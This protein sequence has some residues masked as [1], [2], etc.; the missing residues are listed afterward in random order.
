V[1]GP[2][3]T[4][5]VVEGRVTEWH[6][7][8]RSWRIGSRP[9]IMGILN[10]TPDSFSDGG[11]FRDVDAA[12]DHGCRMEEAGADIIDVGGESTRPGSRRIP[13]EEE[14][15]RVI[16]VVEGLAQRVRCA[17]SV[18][19]TK[20]EV[21]ERALQAGADI[22][23]DVS[24]GR[25]DERMLPVV[26]ASRAGMVLM[27]MKGEP[28]T[29]QAD[30]RYRDVVGE[31][32]D[33]LRERIS[34]CLAAGIR[35]EALAIDPGIGFG[36]RLEHNLALLSAIPRLAGLGRP[37]VIGVSRKSMLGMLTGRPV[38]ERLSA[39]LG[40]AAFAMW[41][42]AHVLRV[43]DVPETRDVV[44]VVGALMESDGGR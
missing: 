24:A 35:R 36:K 23:N 26:A 41:R 44:Q 6:C 16:P 22:V 42:G 40:A 11:R 38:D 9:L 20:A 32:Q 15:R 31:V 3:E 39:S 2:V 30:P 33:F 37:V 19:T 12:V 29:M 17:I 13:L 7:R 8:S 27:H 34:A 5:R 14:L 43:H 25:W 4:E 28:G 1:T 21:A 18:D 10:V